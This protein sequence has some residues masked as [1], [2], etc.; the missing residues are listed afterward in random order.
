[1]LGV[2]C[3]G[4]RAVMLRIELP[5]I[6]A[7]IEGGIVSAWHKKTGDA[8]SYGDALCDIVVQEVTRVRRRLH[9]KAS[10][11]E[12]SRSRAKYRKRTDV[13]LTFRIVSLDSGRLISVEVPE[14]SSVRE[15]KLLATLEP[16]GQTS[17]RVGPSALARVLVREFESEPAVEGN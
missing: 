6:S 2:A 12:L 7:A 10:V 1:M 11:G 15:G 3:G 8:V 16:T 5:R 9:A 4:L 17:E 13:F 14:R